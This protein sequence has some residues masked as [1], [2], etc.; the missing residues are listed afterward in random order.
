MSIKRSFPFVFLVGAG[1]LSAASATTAT[2]NGAD[3]E[4]S[5][6]EVV[7]TA[8]VLRHD[9]EFKTDQTTKVLDQDQMKESSIVG[10]VA[11]ALGVVPGVSTSSYGSTGAAKTTIS[12]DGIKIGWAGFS[13][14]N[15]DNG[16]LGVT[17]DGV[18]MA[19]PGN[20]LWQASLIP[21]TSILQTIGVTYGPGDP[22]ERYFTN[23][24][25]NIAFMPLQPTEAAGGEVALTYGVSKPR[26]SPP[27]I[28][29][30]ST[31]AGRQCWPLGPIMPTVIKTHPTTS[32]LKATI[33]RSI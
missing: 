11:K 10:G 32:K 8:R 25:G 16:S 17:F 2:S 31:T 12:I 30:A 14:G 15:P 7:V 18:P 20:G 6:S 27:I 4:N 13:G 21:Q 3:A 9:E 1:A 24:G 29:S 33:T 28:S 23:I 5:L 19:N 26:T 22:S